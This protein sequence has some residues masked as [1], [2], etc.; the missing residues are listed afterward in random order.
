MTGKY[1]NGELIYTRSIF[2]N[3]TKSKYLEEQMFRLSSAVSMSTDC[4]VITDLDAKIIDA[5]QKILEMYGADSKEELLGKHFLELIVPAERVK[6]SMDVSEIMEKGSLECQEYNMV[7]KQGSRFPVQM[8]TSL[9][10][11]ADGKPMGMVRV[12][13]ELGQLN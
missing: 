11:D 8:S 6:V 9:V 5:N 1:V 13:R 2:R 10:R 4:M 12:G 3:I 7:S